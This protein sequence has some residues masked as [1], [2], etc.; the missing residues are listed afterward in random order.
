MNL[1]IEPF[2]LRGKERRENS[3]LVP[4]HICV[5][6]MSNGGSATS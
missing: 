4:T 2:S 3:E 6:I 1:L 5:D